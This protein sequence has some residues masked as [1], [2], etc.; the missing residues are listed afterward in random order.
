MMKRYGGLAAMIL[1]GAAFLTLPES[2]PV[3]NAQFIDPCAGVLAQADSGVPAFAARYGAAGS[4][5]ALQAVTG[6]KT[7]GLDPDPR[8]RHL[9]ELWKH[10]M[11]VS[12][13]PRG[14]APIE[15]A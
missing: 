10:R 14:I 3:L 1:G 12:R 2:S 13:R 7:P 8:G 11:A 4:R 6:V 5:S 15:G 9:D